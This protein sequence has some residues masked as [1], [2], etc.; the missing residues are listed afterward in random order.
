MLWFHYLLIMQKHSVSEIR[1]SFS[2]KNRGEE[3]WDW[4]F[5][6]SLRYRYFNEI[7]A[8]YMC[9][10]FF[11]NNTFFLLQVQDMFLQSV[12]IR[13]VFFLDHFK[14]GWMI[15]GGDWQLFSG[16]NERSSQSK[17]GFQWLSLLGDLAGA[18]NRGAKQIEERTC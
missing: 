11:S 2:C 5:L 12:L 1:N 10:Y 7:H 13:I 4:T 18:I 15:N 16:L 8:I 9:M 3:K 14:I 6:S 17:N